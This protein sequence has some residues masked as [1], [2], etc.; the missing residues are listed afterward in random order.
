MRGRPSWV[1]IKSAPTLSAVVVQVVLNGAAAQWAYLLKLA[2]AV[3]MASPTG[4][5]HSRGGY[6]RT[7]SCSSVCRRFD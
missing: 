5:V 7:A 4:A 1:W 6:E 2:Y 3:K